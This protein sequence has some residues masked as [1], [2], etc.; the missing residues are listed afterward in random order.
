MRTYDKADGARRHWPDAMPCEDTRLRTEACHTRDMHHIADAA[1]TYCEALF[2]PPRPPTDTI[3]DILQLRLAQMG[4]TDEHRQ[5]QGHDEAEALSSH[6]PRKNSGTVAEMWQQYMDT[7]PS[8]FPRYTWACNQAISDGGPRLVKPVLL[9]LADTKAAIEW[10]QGLGDDESD[11]SGDND[12][13][14]R[15]DAWHTRGGSTRPSRVELR[16]RSEHRAVPRNTQRVDHSGT[17]VHK[18]HGMPRHERVHRSSSDCG[19]GG[20][21][22]AHT[23]HS[24]DRIANRV[25]MCAKMRRAKEP[26]ES[27]R[28]RTRG[29]R[30]GRRTHKQRSPE[31]E[32]D[33]S[34]PPQRNAI[35]KATVREGDRERVV[36]AGRCNFAP[37]INVVG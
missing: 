29:T 26:P 21:G 17:F 4:V 11:G 37:G 7:A 30:R 34:R 33:A 23:Q 6:P 8:A 16:G 3:A 14:S 12:A 20:Q 28:L 1:T 19:V 15:R 5:G 22:G 13:R 25:R 36:A 2:Q 9:T 10:V 18:C 32:I 24:F 35:G 27:G 31:R